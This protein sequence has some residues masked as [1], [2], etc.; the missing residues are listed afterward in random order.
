MCDE[1]PKPLKAWEQW[2]FSLLVA[3]LY[4][5]VYGYQFNCGDQAEHLPQVYQK[6][7]PAL[8]PGDFFLTL[9]HQTFTVRF[10]WVEMVT[11][12]SH[13]LPVPAVCFGLYLVCFVLNNYAW[14]AIAQH[15][16]AQKWAVY[17][18]L[19]FLYIVFNH[20]TVG[21]NQLQ[22]TIFVTSNPAEMCAV[23]G[24][25][26]FIRK[27]YV[28]AALCVAAGTLFQVL[29]GFQVWLILCS[30]LLFSAEPKRLLV[31]V[32]FSA[33]YLLAASPILVPL[34][35]RQFSGN[36][37]YDM[38]LY[39]RT[40]YV[41]RSILHFKPSLFPAADYIKMIMLIVPSSIILYKLRS[42]YYKRIAVIVF[43]TIISGAV[44][45][46]LLIDGLDWNVI[47]MIQWFKTTIWL[48][49]ICCLLLAGWIG[50]RFNSYFSVVERFLKPSYFLGAAVLLLLVVSNGNA[51]PS[52]RLSQRYQVL[53]YSKTDLQLTHEWIR[54]HT[55]VDAVFLVSPLNDAFACEAQRSQP[56]N[57][58][59]VVHEPFYFSRWYKAMEDYYQV[60]FSR[61]GNN[62]AL[63]QAEDNFEH[64][65]KYPAG[66]TA[67]FRIDN[68][69]TSS[70]VAQLG[71]TVFRQ[72]NWIVTKIN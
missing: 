18:S 61:V 52:G 65:L 44:C 7:N 69:Q 28:I 38:D 41:Y 23:W 4:I 64:V 60:D 16:I 31:L 67:Q 56:V 34:L 51:I 59:A 13:V 63:V 33:V 71:K 43:M 45:Y 62:T 66:N 25:L 6:L 70:V 72:G 37:H 49:A 8:Y 15:V 35:G 19:F 12:C 26:F 68:T 29:L 3:V 55:P 2:T 42:S 40:V 57:F 53:N 21:G 30:V 20:F 14:L 11:W 27:R 47:G 50:S 10:Y 9:Y 5:G 22:G 36:Q 39:Y 1:L 58:K 17:L 24:L 46:T 48:N 32:A 54:D